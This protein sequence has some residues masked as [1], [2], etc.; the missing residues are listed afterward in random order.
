MSIIFKAKWGNFSTCNP[1]A[2]KVSNNQ[3]RWC[4]VELPLGNWRIFQNYNG[5]L[6]TFIVVKSS[7]KPPKRKGLDEIL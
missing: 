1:M 7:W 2:V 4:K 3:G 5:D 6:T